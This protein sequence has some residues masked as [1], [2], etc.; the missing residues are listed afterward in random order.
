MGQLSSGTCFPLA[1]S[2][3]WNLLGFNR[4]IT[5]PGLAGDNINSVQNGILLRDHMHTLFDTYAFSISVKYGYK[6][7]CF[8]RDKDNIAGT[9]LSPSFITDPRRS[10]DELLNWHFRQAVLTNMKGIGEPFFENDFPPGSDMVGQ[11]LRGPKPRERMEFELFM[12][13]SHLMDNN[14]NGQGNVERD[15]RDFEAKR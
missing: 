12:R 15:G 14:R 13:L 2:G 11:I 6:V 4:H 9:Y 7:I 1:Y 8:R 3:I 10:P 5:I